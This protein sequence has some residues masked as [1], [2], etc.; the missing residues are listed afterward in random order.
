MRDLIN[1]EC[2]KYEG[3]KPPIPTRG[4]YCFFFQF[5][6]QIIN[7][8]FLSGIVTIGTAD[9]VDVDEPDEPIEQE[10]INIQDFLPRVDISN[11]ITEVLLSELGDK[12]WKVRN[13]ALG[14]ITAI[15]H[16][17]KHIKPSLGDLPQILAVRL[18]D[19]N[20]KIAQSALNLCEAITK[21]M[22]PPCKQYIK[23]FLPGFLQGIEW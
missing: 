22:G 13:E 11:Q 19:S 23:V 6:I 1:A 20:L 12:N 7:V 21:A 10:V 9:N 4:M 8:L 14:K 18:T 3:N 15:L 17:A 5:D 16:D 2:D